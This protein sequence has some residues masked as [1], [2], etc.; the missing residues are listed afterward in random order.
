M[1]ADVV[2]EDAA[3]VPQPPLMNMEDAMKIAK[4]K[5]GEWVVY[6]LSSQPSPMRTY[7]GV[8]NDWPHR[9]RQHNGEIKGGASAT[10]TSRPWKLSALMHGFGGGPEG[11]SLAMRAEW[12]GKVKHYNKPVPGKTGPLRRAFL[13]EYAKE[14]CK[15]K[16]DKEVTVCYCDPNMVSSEQK[17]KR[18]KTRAEE[19]EKRHTIINVSMNASLSSDGKVAET[20]K[21]EKEGGEEL[22]KD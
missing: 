7:C 5:V 6:V 19:E 22:T 17:D 14:M 2:N 16:S 9:F 10:R 1:S 12:F 20:E 15:R 4:D 13:L 21:K 8:T 11:K 3:P 18:D